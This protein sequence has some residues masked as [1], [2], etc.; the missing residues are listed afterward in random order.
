MNSRLK[1]LTKCQSFWPLMVLLAI[2]LVNGVVSG[3]AFFQMR[4]VDG[5]LYGRLI[6]ILRNGSKLMLLATGMTMVLATGGTDISVGSVMAISGAIACSVVNGRILSSLGGSVTAAVLIAVL[7]GVL[8]GA[9]NGLLVSKIKI[10]PIVATMILM[11]AGRGIAQ[12]ITDGKIVTVNSD[13]YYFINGGYILGLPFPLFIVGF[14]VLLIMLFTKK[15][16]FG[17]FVESTGCNPVSSRFAG[18]NVD[19]VKLVIYTFCGAMAAIAGLIESGGHQGRRLQ[20]RRPDDRDGRDPRGRDRRHLPRGRAVLDPRLDRRRADHPVDHHLGLRN[21]RRP[22]GHAGGQGPHRRRDLPGAVEEVQGRRRGQADLPEGGE[23]GVS[24]LEKTRRRGGIKNVSLFIT[25]ILFVGLFAAGSVRYDRFLSLS[26]FLNLFN[27]NAYLIIVSVGITFVLLTGGIDISVASTLAFTCVFSAF[28][29]RL[30][31]PA[32]VVIPLVLLIGLGVGA[33][34]GFLIHSYD[35][36]PFI[37]T[38]AGQFFMRGL[39]AVIS[40]ESIPISDGFY[41]SMALGKVAFGKAKLYYY[42]FIAL[43]VVALAYY[44]LKYTKFGRGVY[45]VGGGEQSAVLM[46]LPVARTKISVYAISGFCA[47]LAGVV[48]SFYTLA[49]YSLQNMG[50]ELDAISSAV[51]GGTL[52]TGGVG[53]VIGTMFGVLIQGVIQTIVTYQNLN[54]WWTKV[55]IAALLCVFIVIQRIIA[56]RAEKLKNKG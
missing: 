55:T 40:T 41:K 35:L 6:D 31:V 16:A 49:G 11:V 43:A 3:G 54:T 5:H 1:K 52:L 51:I 7:A 50:L 25:V 2:L 39:C 14:F 47:A 21:G 56:I 33:L 32:F 36:Q 30:G 46:G 29:L 20:Q 8:C 13:A 18:I 38:L 27:D 44:V 15:T 17:L 45:A 10:Q 34:M 23:R 48:F 22:R 37:V 19:R 9:W 4:I 24:T 42:V 26:T 28:L 12:L 53:T